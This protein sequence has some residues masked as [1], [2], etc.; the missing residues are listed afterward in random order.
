MANRSIC[1][2]DDDPAEVRRVEKYLADRFAVGAG[3]TLD[4]ALAQFGGKAP[5]LFVLDLYF[6][7]G[8]TLSDDQ[9]ARLHKARVTYLTAERKFRR[10]LA[11]LGQS[12]QGGFILARDVRR[13]FRRPV[14]FFTRK[15]TLEDAITAYEDLGVA[16]V[17]KK[18]DPD[19]VPRDAEDLSSLYDQAMKDAAPVVSER[20]ARVIERSSWLARH[21]SNVV[22]FGFGVLT[23]L[24]GTAIWQL[25]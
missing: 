1:F 17:G 18:P 6:P 23:S 9:L 14:A 12:A 10:L 19:D 5:D 25:L 3:Q 11:E 16:A 22:G 15:G 4:D 7:D 24:V 13:R 21:R 8:P 2:V 20:F